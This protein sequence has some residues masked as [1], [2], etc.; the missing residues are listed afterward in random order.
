MFNS[1]VLDVVIG[2]IFIYLIYSLLATTLQE[3][4]ASGF[5]FRSKMLERA[6]FRML[7]DKTK[8]NYGISSVF[9]LFKKQ[10]NGGDPDSAS[11][12]FYNHPLIKFLGGNKSNNKPSYIKKETFSKVIVDLLRGDQ[13]EHGDNIKKV[14]SEALENK[15][16]NWGKL[17]VEIAPE[18]LSFIK[19][20]WADSQN[21]VEKFRK[22]LE[23]WF[24]ETMERTTDWYRKHTQFILFFIGLIIAVVFN[25]DSIKITQ[26]LQKDPKLREQIVQQANT[27]LENNPNL[28]EDLN[29]N[30]TKLDSLL[31]EIKK[32][33]TNDTDQNAADSLANSNYRLLTDY[34]KKMIERA[35]SLI[36]TDLQKAN[37]V[38]GL[39]WENNNSDRCDL[40]SFMMSLLGW[41]ITALAISLGAP[42]WYDLLTKFMK[43][44]GGVKETPATEKEEKTK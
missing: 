24:D 28:K 29:S 23:I 32:V 25:V 19:S 38:L 2:L 10:G 44:K 15:T 27:F 37:A 35:D 16:F 40:K 14:I 12:T 3:L 11:F 33:S 17:S 43:L 7:E 1:T 42:F 20:I 9:Y 5:G 26:K 39:G 8:F 22:N 36:S 4:I 18:T 34:Q 13:F 6:I 41:I 21:D 30:K 31:A